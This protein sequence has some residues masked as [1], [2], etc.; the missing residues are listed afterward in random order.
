MRLSWN[1]HIRYD[2]FVA[3]VIVLTSEARVNFY[4]YG[5]S[6]NYNTI[7]AWTCLS[8]EEYTPTCGWK[9]VLTSSF[10][11][12]SMSGGSEFFTYTMVSEYIFLL[13]AVEKYANAEL[14]KP[15]C[16]NIEMNGEFGSLI[17][18]VTVYWYCVCNSTTSGNC[19]NVE[20][21]GSTTTTTTTTTTMAP[22]ARDTGFLTP[23]Y[24]SLEAA[25]DAATTSPTTVPTTTS[26]TP[27]S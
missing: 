4:K 15:S 6:N 3:M 17:P 22:A 5:G 8:Y 20:Q 1:E 12:S 25:T 16:P 21:S 13:N 11:L 7:Y 10:P 26:T 14:M 24:E 19:Q 9:L 23:S 18:N 27:T 2:V